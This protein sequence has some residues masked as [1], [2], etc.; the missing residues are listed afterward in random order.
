M[1]SFEWDASKAQRNQVA[2]GVTF[3]EA[4]SAFAEPLGQIVDDPRHSG[5]EARFALLAQS[6]RKRLLVI[7]FTER[8]ERIR[9]I[10]ARRATSTERRQYEEASR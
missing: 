7:M 10:S 4:A 9:V 2:H 3:D 1:P 8:G 5:A 6:E